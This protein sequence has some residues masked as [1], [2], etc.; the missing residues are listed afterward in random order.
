[1]KADEMEFDGVVTQAFK[2][3]QFK[4]ELDVGNDK[5]HEVMCTI[6]G[7]LKI[8]YIKILVGDKVKVVVNPADV[9]KGRIIWR[10]K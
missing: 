4:V 3:V 7:R 6:S 1:M 2:G 10:Y 5:K 8:N 9:S